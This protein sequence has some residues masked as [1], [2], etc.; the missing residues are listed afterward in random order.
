MASPRRLGPYDSEDDFFEEFNLMKSM[1]EDIYNERGQQRGEGES[2]VKEEGGGEGGGLLKT[3]FTTI[4][5]I[6]Y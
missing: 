6:I 5:I 2:L 1:V 3:F 4:I